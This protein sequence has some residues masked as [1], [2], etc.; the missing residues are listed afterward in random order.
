MASPDSTIAEYRLE[1]LGFVGHQAVDAKIQQSM[2]FN[3]IVDSPDM[4]VNSQFVCVL[5]EPLSDYLN[6]TRPHRHLD[7]VC[8]SEW[9]RNAVGANHQRHDASS[10]GAERQTIAEQ[11]A[12]S[13]YAPVAEGADENTIQG[14]G[15]QNRLGQRFD[16]S[17]ALRIE[18]D[19]CTRE[20]FKQFTDPQN[21]LRAP[22]PCSA[23]L[24]PSRL[25]NV[26]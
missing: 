1:D 9:N 22:N 20:R 10:A 21:R 2:H 17:V 3:G 4:N 19:A 24:V 5:N 23:D 12:R 7:R 6:T 8:P 26:T 18:V 16:R 25:G 15:C 11:S 13:V 14:I